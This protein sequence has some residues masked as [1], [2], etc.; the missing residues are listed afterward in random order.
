M[1]TNLDV[2]LS[3]WEKDPGNFLNPERS[4]SSCFLSWMMR[5]TGITS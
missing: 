2:L 3:L 1:S 5:A 4:F